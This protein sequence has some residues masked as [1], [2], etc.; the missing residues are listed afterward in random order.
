MWQYATC[1]GC[2][3]ERLTLGRSAAVARCEACLLAEIRGPVSDGTRSL[4]R[5][6]FASVEDEA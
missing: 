2:N 4:L 5:R 1:P 6:A 3:R